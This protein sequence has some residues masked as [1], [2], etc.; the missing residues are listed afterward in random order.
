MSVVL[1]LLA[2]LAYG[3]SDFLGGL[4]SRRARAITVLLYSY[5]IGTA[6]MAVPLAFDAGPVSA[7]TLLWSIGGGAFGLVGV[8]LMYSAMA[9]APLNVV[10]PITA[11][12]TAAVPVAGGVLIGE[13]PSVQ[14]WIGVVVGLGAIALVSRAPDPDPEQHAPAQDRVDV[15]AGP[16]VSTPA[17]LMALIAGVGFGAYFLCLAGADSDSG[18]WPVVLA[19]A[20]AS[21]LCVLLVR[22][23]GA[24][25]VL[26]RS[27]VRLTL[28]VGVLDAA[29]NAFFLLAARSGYL[30]L[31]GLLTSLYPAGTVALA[32]VLLRERTGALQRLGF[33]FAAV[34]VLL[35]IR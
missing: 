29:A 17:V 5:P 16:R 6:V 11:T 1:A 22:A 9:I 33:G 7:S 14:S 34:A 35:L 27:A 25:A 15:R 2:A 3:I 32:V 12:C 19:R 8:L 4:A 26:P 28:G 24:P 23:M 10:S 13:R 30:S 21:L 18:M 31:A 20:A